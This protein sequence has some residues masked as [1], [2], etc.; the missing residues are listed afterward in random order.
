M[1]SSSGSTDNRAGASKTPGDVIHR[2]ETHRKIA[3]YRRGAHEHDAFRAGQFAP[4]FGDIGPKKFGPENLI[5]RDVCGVNHRRRN[6]HIRK[7]IV[8]I[9]GI[10]RESDADLLEV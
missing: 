5:A 8:I 3:E 10:K 9:F 6:G 2:Q 7:E 1:S 4:P